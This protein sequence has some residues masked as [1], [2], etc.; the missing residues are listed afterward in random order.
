MP[1]II[2]LSYDRDLTHCGKSF[3]CI[4][5]ID[6]RH[7]LDI[8]GEIN[9]TFAMRALDTLNAHT[10]PPEGWLFVNTIEKL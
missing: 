2:F 10:E 5:H 9:D 4:N 6:S 7:D 8:L 3:L 1:D